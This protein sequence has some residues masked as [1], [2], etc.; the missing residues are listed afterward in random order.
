MTDL[1]CPIR[2][3]VTTVHNK[4][5]DFHTIPIGI[6]IT[7]DNDI[8]YTELLPCVGV[9]CAAFDKKTGKCLYFK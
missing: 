8:S 6:N 4:K 1:L 3:K 2:T 5:N 7:N 9:N